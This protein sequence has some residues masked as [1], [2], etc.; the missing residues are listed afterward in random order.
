MNYV[1]LSYRLFG[2][3]SRSIRPYFLDIKD[4][5]QRANMSFTLEEYLSTA[6]FTASIAFFLEAV[7]LAFIFGFLGFSIVASLLLSITLSGTISGILF[8][9]FYTYPATI[10]KTREGKIRKILPFAVSYMATIASSKLPP[11]I[12]FKTIS[13]FREYGEVAEE[14]KNISRDVEVFGMT[15]SAAIKKQAKRTPS[16]DFRELLWGIN[17]VFTSGGDLTFYFKQKGDELMADYKRRIEKYSQNISLFV[18]IYLTLI[19][20]GSIFFIVLSSVISSISGGL[21]TIVVQSFAIFILLPL[22]SVGFI[23][24]LKSLSPIG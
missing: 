2:D 5:L 24:I 7:S 18:E 11:I 8:F 17:S 14:S 9:L 4:D 23:L 20:T 13:H 12:L 1:L 15:F 10:S 3:I 16:K 21:G 22:L 6:A 19:I